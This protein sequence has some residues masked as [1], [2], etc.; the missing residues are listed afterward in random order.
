MVYG[1]SCLNKGGMNMNNEN[2]KLDEVK[3]TTIKEQIENK[4]H[5]EN[6]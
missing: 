5:A 4:T 6:F 1:K 3:E 2:E